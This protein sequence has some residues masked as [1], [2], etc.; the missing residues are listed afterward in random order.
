MTT[1]RRDFLKLAGALVASTA[2]PWQSV[3]ANPAAL[4]VAWGAVPVTLLPTQITSDVEVAVLNGIFDYLLATNARSELVP[5]LATS[6]AIS[7]DGS[8]YTL[9]IVSS[10]KFHDNSPLT[11][12]DIIWTFERLRD[13]ANATSS[14]YENIDSVA[15][16]SENQIVFRLKSPNPDFL[17]DLTDYHALVLKK[18]EDGSNKNGTGAFRFNDMVEGKRVTL[19][20]NPAYWGK[21]PTI[22]TLE[23][24]FF[25]DME[26]AVNALRAATVDAIMRVD[27]MTLL[28]LSSEFST[29]YI[30]T[31]G[32]DLIRLRSDRGPGAD[33]RVRQAL[34][35]ATDR[36][37]IFD[38]TQ[39]GFGAVGRDTPI[40]PVFSAYY[41][42]E[43]PIPTRDP[44]KAR[45]LLA[46]AGYP[47]GLDLTLNVP[48]TPGRVAT[49][50]LL[51][52]Q[53]AEAGIYV[54]VN[55]LDETKYYSDNGWLDVDLG[56]TAWGPRPTP[57]TYLKYALRTGAKWNESHFSDAEL[58]KHI[59]TATQTSNEAE[60]VTAYHE[61]QRILIERGP[62]IVPY[63]FAA[64]MVSKPSV[65]NV[66]LHPF[67]GL[68]DF[69]YATL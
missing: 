47:Q 6:W 11:L 54:K 19:T 66:A 40:S 29:T 69:R 62:L 20:A 28:K 8:T 4:R 13:P 10:A 35:L 23:M 58:D 57:S 33:V 27:N 46:D 64:T 2:L 21:V 63:F 1:S 37:A 26:Q 16:G 14:L 24:D 56:M 55:P 34:R 39:Y 65:K 49:A 42:E 52:Q 51:S 31:S 60:R 68:T 36:Q 18:G 22:D 9:D 59:D 15:K 48:D 53:W 12:D 17:Y 32:H 3:R 61:I 44:Q 50:S 41:S 38:N 43:V 5:R 25:A 67:A 7:Q 30:P 45:Q